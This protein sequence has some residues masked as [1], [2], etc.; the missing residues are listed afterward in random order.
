MR[1]YLLAGN[2]RHYDGVIA[3]LEARGL[4]VRAAYSSGLDARPAVEQFFMSN[5]KPN[6][7]SGP[8]TVFHDRRLPEPATPAPSARL[9]PFLRQR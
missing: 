5:G 3:A 8:I 4:N 6:R 7:F 1:S 9:T 2:A